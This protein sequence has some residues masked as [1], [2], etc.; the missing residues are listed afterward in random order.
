M[1]SPSFAVTAMEDRLS[2]SMVEAES[3]TVVP[4][5]DGIVPIC[6]ALSWGPRVEGWVTGTASTGEDAELGSVVRFWGDGN[7]GPEAGA[8]IVGVPFW[9]EIVPVRSA[10][11]HLSSSFAA[12]GMEGR[13]SCFAGEVERGAEADGTLVPF[14]PEIVPICSVL[15]WRLSGAGDEWWAS[16]PLPS[17]PL[18]EERGTECARSRFLLFAGRVERSCWL[19]SGE[20]EGEETAGRGLMRY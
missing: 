9:G 2:L 7:A 18:V 1:L 10:G 17:P 15:G 3:G 4:S 13:L 12:A 19:S 20:R 8:P 14:S 5:W 6:S 11:R 16:S